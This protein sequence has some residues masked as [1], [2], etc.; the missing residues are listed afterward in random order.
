MATNANQSEGNSGTKA[1]TF[2]VNRSV[3]TTG[4]NAV[5]W[6][7]TGSG[8]NPA[9][10]TDFL[11]GV[12]PSGTVS[13]AP[14]ETSKGFTV[15]V[16]G[17]TTVEQNENFTVTL[18]NTTNGATITTATATGT[19]QNDDGNT[20]NTFS[21]TNPI[22][23]QDATASNPYPSTINVSGLNG[24]LASLKVTLTNL[25]HTWPD[26][27]DALLVGPT[28]AKIILMSDVGGSDD[29]NNITLTFDPLATAALPDSGL[30]T[31]GT[32]LPT[33]FAI[34]DLF[35]SP[36]PIGPY[37]T[38]FS[39]FNNTNPNGVWSLYI[40]DD[41]GGDAGD[42]AGGWSL[43][44]GTTSTNNPTLAI[45]ATNAN[46]TEG[47]I[48]TKPFT[49]TVNRSVNTTGINA[50][51]WAVTGSGTN[52]ANATDFAGGVLP[53]GIVSFAGGE[54]SKVITIN[55]QGDT[56]VEQNENFTVTLSNPTNGATITT[57]TATGTIQNDDSS[58]S[59]LKLLGVSADNYL[60]DLN[61]QTGLA[62]NPR[63]TV[64]IALI[65]ITQAPD[66]KLYGITL[67]GIPT[68]PN[69]FPSSLYLI[70]SDTGKTSLVQ[71]TNVTPV[72]EGDLDFDPTTGIM[73]GVLQQTVFPILYSINIT[74]GKTTKIATIGNQIRDISRLAFAP[75]GS[76]YALDTKNDQ[77]LQ[78]NKL[79]GELISSVPLIT[80]TGTTVDLGSTA[81]M[82]FN[83]ITGELFVADGDGVAGFG[84]NKL[85]TLNIT[86]GVLNP[87]GDLGLTYGLSG[88]EF[89]WT[90]MPT[91]P[92]LMISATNA[93][94]TE[95]NSG[96]KDFTFTVTRAVNITGEN[97]V[98]WA[99]TGSG[100]N[101]ANAADFLNGVL[102]SGTVSFA[103]SETSKVIAVKVQGDTTVEHN[104][105]FTVTLSNP[106]NG[107]TITTA[108]ATGTITNDDNNYTTIESVGNT[109]LIKDGAN[110]LFTQVGSDTP[111]AVNR[112]G[113]QLYEGYAGWSFLAA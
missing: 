94:Q 100:T 58:T 74:N 67:Q 6:A 93:N 103:A 68:P 3:N 40:M 63:Y 99:V 112:N 39:V 54:T 64:Q 30:I 50:V 108:T 97:T 18:S 10:A 14:G 48:G 66:G 33:D 77:L 69:A 12:L 102:P 82:D 81:G 9:N 32:Y 71:R 56:T 85:Y 1:F 26:D 45:A 42:I 113:S 52:P 31:S 73:Y 2:T 78:I 91:T 17:D 104:E 95:G 70:D 21:N 27:I 111:V 59:N 5:N 76:L 72:T 106:T 7:V 34:G 23:I 60:Y 87:I 109:S 79:S 20:G 49:F 19:I 46:Q 96:S 51:N 38:D 16:Q 37:G 89:V 55:V 8:T 75:N 101:P 44:I 43:T 28:G 62:S 90:D 107:A 22:T 53:S 98:N 25:S 4:T 57:A 65:D 29:L 84:T 11:N 88:L 36:A 24:N 35:N 92:T 47:N 80:P 86:N 105:N 83:P 41:T 61:V 13:F 110:K 15:N